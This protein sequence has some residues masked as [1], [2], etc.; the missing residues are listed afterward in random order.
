MGETGVMLLDNKRAQ[1]V[2]VGVV[3]GVI[4]VSLALSLLVGGIL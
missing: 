3:V 2:V 4:V 1:K